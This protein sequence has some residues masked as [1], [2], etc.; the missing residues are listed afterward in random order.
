MPSRCVMVCAA[1][2]ALS[3]VPCMHAWMIYV[4]LTFMIQGHC[5]VAVL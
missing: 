1:T 2:F 3:R 4:L 5:K